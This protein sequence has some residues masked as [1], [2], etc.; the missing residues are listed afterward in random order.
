MSLFRLQWLLHLG[1]NSFIFRKEITMHTFLRAVALSGGVLLCSL[2]GAQSSQ[3]SQSNMRSMDPPANKSEAAQLSQDMSPQARSQLARREAH[4]AYKEALSACKSMDRAE[5]KG[6]AAEAKR[7]LQQDLSYAKALRTQDTSVGSSGAGDSSG[8][9]VSGSSSSSSSSSPS[10]ASSASSPINGHGMS[11][12]GSSGSDLSGSNGSSGMGG[13]SGASGASGTS[14]TSG[15]S[16]MGRPDLS[17]GDLKNDRPSSDMS[18]EKLS[19]AEKKQFVQSFSPQAQYNLSK[20]EAHAAYAEALKACKEL[21]KSERAA[22][23]KE[24]RSTLQQDLAYAK[25]Q[26]QQDSSGVSSGGGTDSGV[27]GPAK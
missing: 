3:S 24:A 12:G 17:Q 9:G 20:R 5:R 2:A 8:S 26:L 7:N 23:T 16:M 27:S 10:G 4:A 21:S 15:G 13:T 18:S 22:C 25:S 1:S 19:S 11:S 6:C 14:T